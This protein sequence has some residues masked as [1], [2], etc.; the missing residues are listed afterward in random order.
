[1]ER[2]AEIEGK[3]LIQ[4]LESIGEHERGRKRPIMNTHKMCG[5]KRDEISTQKWKERER[6]KRS[7]HVD[8][9]GKLDFFSLLVVVLIYVYL[10]LSF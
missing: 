6:E 3:Q 9:H 4:S 1:M 7:D 2:I 5:L 10:S 8:Y